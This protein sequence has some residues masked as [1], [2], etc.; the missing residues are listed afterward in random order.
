MT[1]PRLCYGGSES[2]ANVCDV[3]HSN[4]KFQKRG[5]AGA[6]LGQS[7]SQYGSILRSMNPEQIGGTAMHAE[8]CRSSARW[9]FRVARGGREDRG[10]QGLLLGTLG[11]AHGSGAIAVAPW[12]CSSGLVHLGS[13]VQTPDGFLCRCFFHSVSQKSPGS[14]PSCFPKVDR[15]KMPC[16]RSHAGA[17]RHTT[18]GGCFP[19]LP[20]PTRTRGWPA[21]PRPR[22]RPAG[23][24][25]R[26]RRGRTTA[27]TGGSCSSRP[28]PL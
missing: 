24:P 17:L 22:R 7:S 3:P 19:A 15:S 20:S 27:R 13:G 12:A 25:A 11:V 23:N 1:A 14:L 8:A 16:Q 28:P 6:L 2:R 4:R 21:A 18:D 10:S 26:T 5:S 9:R